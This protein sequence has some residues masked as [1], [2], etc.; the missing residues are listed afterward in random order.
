VR[1]I[2]KSG[3]PKAL[4]DWKAENRRT[5]QNLRFENCPKAEIRKALLAEQGFLCAYTMLRLEKESCCHV[6]HVKAQATHREH[7]LDYANMLACFPSNGGDA[8]HGFGAPLKGDFHA[9]EDNFVSPLHKSCETRFS[10]RQS[11]AVIAASETDPAARNT[12]DIL[13]LD[14]PALRDKR[15]EVLQMLGLAIG[16]PTR[17]PT[18]K[19]KRSKAI[20]SAALARRLAERASAFDKNGKLQ[21]FCIAIKQNAERYANRE[22]KRAARISRG[23]HDR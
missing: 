14:H 3:E 6:E 19:A 7:A 11:G 10:Y 1:F 8:S 5:P 13:R 12:I 22:E 17:D 9:T 16:I 15:R 23:R 20:I 2:A 18:R 21:P 4:R